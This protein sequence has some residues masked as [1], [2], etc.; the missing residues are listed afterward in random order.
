[1]RGLQ[2]SLRC[3]SFSSLDDYTRCACGL[4]QGYKI[5]DLFCGV[6]HFQELI[7]EALEFGA[8]ADLVFALLQINMTNKG[9]S[10]RD[11]LV[12]SNLK[13]RKIVYSAC[14]PRGSD[15]ALS[16]LLQF[17]APM[18]SMC[19]YRYPDGV[20]IQTAL[21]RAVHYS[22][23]S[24]VKMLLRR[25]ADVGLHGGMSS[26][27]WGHR[28]DAAVSPLQC[29]LINVKDLNAAY[30]REIVGSESSVLQSLEHRACP[31]GVASFSR[32]I[33]RPG[34]LTYAKG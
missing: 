23:V 22:R 3:G 1:M 27:R 15:A 17:G 14:G 16:L 9:L 5:G 13:G 19:T 28:H 26:E 25:G 34:H 31:Y 8:D 30:G 32:P 18:N 6:G 21:Y 24:A 33:L 11:F 4:V 10:M 20:S 12:D 7:C 2:S 29:A